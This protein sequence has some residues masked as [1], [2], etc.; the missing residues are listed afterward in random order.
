MK[1]NLHHDQEFH[2]QAHNKDVKAKSYA[3]CDKVWLNSKSY[4][5]N[6]IENW[7][8]NFL[9]FFESSTW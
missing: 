8:T 7:S 4:K 5:T 1:K 9:N 6:K 3:P 2:K